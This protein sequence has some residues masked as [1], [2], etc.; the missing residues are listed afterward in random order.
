MNLHELTRD[1]LIALVRQQATA[2]EACEAEAVARQMAATN[3]APGDHKRRQHE[4]D[5]AADRA[6][7]LRKEALAK[8]GRA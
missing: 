1:Q 7:R 2:L 5:I 8:G 6:A 3:T 4:L